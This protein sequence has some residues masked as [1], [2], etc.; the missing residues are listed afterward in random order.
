MRSSIAGTAIGNFMEWFDFGIYGYLATTLAQVFYPGGRAG[1]L[2]LIATFGTMAAAFVVR[3]LGGLVFGPLGD[4][5]GRKRVLIVTI[6]VMASAT[7]TTGLLPDYAAI[8]AWAPLLLVGARIL[9]GLST[10][11]EY[12]GA[13]TYL[14]E[15]APDRRRGQLAAFLPL[16]TW[17]GYV[18]GAALVVALHCA[19]TTGQMLSWGW[20]IPFLLG[21]PLGLVTLSLRTRLAESADYQKIDDSQHMSGAGG[22]RQFKRTV[23]QQWRPMLICI[24]LVLTFNVTASVLAGYL[25]TYLR[26]VVRIGE[27]GGLVMLV[28]VLAMV[29]SAVVFVAKL[30]DRVGAKPILWTGCGLLIVGSVPAFEL[31]RSGGSSPEVFVGVASVGV[32]LLCFTSIEPSVL[33][34]LFPTSVRYGAL[35]I[36]FNISTSAFGGTTPLVAESLITATGNVMVPAFMLIAAG[37]VGVVTLVFTPEVAGRRL[38]GS[39][40]SVDSE[41]AARDIAAQPR[42]GLST[43]P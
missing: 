34:P 28:A 29:A 6:V 24:G 40:P 8:G 4:R 36:G 18:V 13:M 7:T 31:I 17:S 14:D 27:T 16:G 12:V 32:M 39:G 42:P 20:R 43:G 10:G 5:I 38:P 37:V 25:P 11:G 35:A 22:G 15:Q 33:P 26:K 21:A 1:G 3:P 19:L 9:Q 23:V 2:G 30:S 41:Q